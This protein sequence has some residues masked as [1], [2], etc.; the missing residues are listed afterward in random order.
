MQHA[1]AAQSMP[2]G[3]AACAT[4]SAAEL[5]R[6]SHAQGNAVKAAWSAAPGLTSIFKPFGF[7]TLKPPSLGPTANDIQLYGAAVTSDD[8]A[9][10][11]K[12]GAHASKHEHQH[13]KCSRRRCRGEVDREV[14][15]A[16]QVVERSCTTTETANAAV[17]MQS[18][19]G[20]ALGSVLLGCCRI[21]GFK[22]RQAGLE[23]RALTQTC[24]QHAGAT[25]AR[26]EEFLK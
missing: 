12:P 24:Q 13:S 4:P 11:L 25:L 19:C 3:T 8:S 6:C 16:R 7:L 17:R 26:C 10:V 18:T 5:L 23:I 14:D 2:W 15:K 21:P 1:A 9:A 20:I 22:V